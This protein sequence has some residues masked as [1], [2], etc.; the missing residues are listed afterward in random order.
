M[1]AGH[2]L[3]AVIP[4]QGAAEPPTSC[5]GCADNRQIVNTWLY[6]AI[7]GGHNCSK[8]NSGDRTDGEGRAWKLTRDPLRYR[9]SR[10][11]GD[12]KEGTFQAEVLR[13]DCV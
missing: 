6:K 4:D 3:H 11:L 9:V 12:V 8:V 5:R 1:C 7:S 10:A 13:W 2:A